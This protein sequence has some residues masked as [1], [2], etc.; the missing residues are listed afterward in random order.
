MSYAKAMKH[1]R[2]LRKCRKQG[3]NYLGFDTGS[4]RWPAARSNPYL[5]ALL[6]VREWFRLRNWGDAATRTYT[7]ECIREALQEA[8]LAK[9]SFQPI[10]VKP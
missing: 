9:Q 4:G 7:R 5:A 8:R 1:S 10:G 2:N 3:R 6:N